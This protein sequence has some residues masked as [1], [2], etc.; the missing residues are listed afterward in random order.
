MHESG[1]NTSCDFPSDMIIWSECIKWNDVYRKDFELTIF[2]VYCKLASE[3][4]G[5]KYI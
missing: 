4:F 3:C 1:F 5:Y 2:E